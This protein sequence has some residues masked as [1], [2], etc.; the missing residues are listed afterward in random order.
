MH[1]IELFPKVI[2]VS[3]VKDTHKFEALK[4]VELKNNVGNSSSK[5]SYILNK[6]EYIDLKKELEALLNEHLLTVYNPKGAEDLELY[7]TQSWV[8]HTKKNEF[9]HRHTHANSVLSGVVY[10]DIDKKVDNI[11]FFTNN[12]NNPDTLLK[13]VPAEYTIYNSTAW[14]IKEL[15]VGDVIIF[16]STLSHGVDERGSAE[17]KRISLAFNSFIKGTVGQYTDYTELVLKEEPNEL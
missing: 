13:L 12:P 11:T 4:Q 5:E 9:H 14:T 15:S 3:N 7:I 2:S 8:N 10:L 1:L 17:T 16:P 6:P